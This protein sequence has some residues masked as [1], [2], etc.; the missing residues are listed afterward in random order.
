MEAARLEHPDKARSILA[1]AVSELPKS[2]KLWAAAANK[3]TDKAIKIKILKRALEH[4]PNNVGLWKELIELEGEGEA[5]DLL[6]KAVE[7]CPRSLDLWIGLAKL[8]S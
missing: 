5:K 1:K 2:V 3:E 7:C 4:I 8:E 6:Y